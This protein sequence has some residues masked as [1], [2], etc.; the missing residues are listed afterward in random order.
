M[1]Y[2]KPLIVA[3][4]KMNPQNAKEAK[5]L[6]E[7]V[8]RGIKTVKNAQVVICPPFVYLSELKGLT[9][10]AQNVS[11]EEKGAFTGAI[12][13][14]QLKDLKV[15]YIILGHSE[16]RQ[17]FHETDEA[18]NKRVKKVLDAGLKPILCVGENMD[19]D[20]IVI[21]EK[22]ITEGLKSIPAKEIKNIAVAYEPVWAIG[23]RKNCSIDDTM[24]SVLLIRK[25]I[26]NLYNREAANNMKI[27]YGGS[28][29]SKN[30]GEYI[31]NAGVDG[32]LVGGASLDAEE[33]IKI[34]KSAG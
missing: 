8:K 2:M 6:F 14:L 13:V 29:N 23:T 10:G 12:S 28:V 18:I 26:S 1:K 25:I 30:S 4:W 9:L 24:G 21:L 31:K 16:R 33:F 5:K 11:R 17:Y 15:E 7:F 32:L 3:N 34:I 20:K 22:Q 19:E 27:L